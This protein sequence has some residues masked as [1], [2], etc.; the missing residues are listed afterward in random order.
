MKRNYLCIFALLF[1]SCSDNS[2]NVPEYDGPYT[3]TL[4]N[5]TK[6]TAFIVR[7]ISEN[8]DTTISYVN[9]GKSNSIDLDNVTTKIEFTS[10]IKFTIYAT[11]DKRIVSDTKLIISDAEG[12]KYKISKKD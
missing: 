3:V 9:P 2:S 4:L 12:D 5:E 7:F 10:G 1:M 6:N 8:A 11:Y